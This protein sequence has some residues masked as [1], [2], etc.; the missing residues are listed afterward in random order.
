[1]EKE[2]DRQSVDVHMLKIE[3]KEAHTFE[4]IVSAIC[5]LLVSRAAS[6]V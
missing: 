3:V 1:M 2:T 6:E 4:S 5:T